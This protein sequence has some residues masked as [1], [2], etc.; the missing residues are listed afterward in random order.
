MT[1][2]KFLPIA[3]LLLLIACW[4]A[5]VQ[6]VS[7]LDDPD[8]ISIESV[9][10]YNNVAVSGDALFVVY[11][12]LEYNVLPDESIFEGWVG[13]LI[14]VGGLGQLAS[15]NP[16]IAPPIPNDGYTRGIYS[17]YFE[18]MP[19]T[20]GTLSVT[21]EGNPALDPTPQGISTGSIQT[22]SA[23]NL[24]L[25]LVIIALQLEPVW[26]E[27]LIQS[28][29]LTEAGQNY[30]LSAIPGLRTYAPG[31]FVLGVL[32]VNP[33]DFQDPIDFTFRDGLRDFWINTPFGDFLAAWSN[34]MS[35]PQQ[36]F[37]TGIVFGILA[38]ICTPVVQRFGT[39]EPALFIGIMGLVV[40]SLM[41][42]GYPELTYT[43]AVVSALILG[44]IMF[45][46]KGN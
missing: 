25:D 19:F 20:T 17:F 34:A 27:S 39:P 21:L 28:G 46:N 22:R 42:L 43:F 35:L 7:A 26:A 16:S 9:R 33:E 5:T 1:R 2:K 32:P 6:P 8:I 14:D 3:F 13:R 36:L 23:T 11:Y 18:S 29:R 31:L 38:M 41:G 12:R 44:W 24:Q 40:A 4:A 30:F 37:E 10:R 45:F 15:V